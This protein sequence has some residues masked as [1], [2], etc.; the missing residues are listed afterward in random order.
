M[1]SGRRSRYG[2]SVLMRVFLMKEAGKGIETSAP[3]SLLK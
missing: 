2:L 1:G 3:E